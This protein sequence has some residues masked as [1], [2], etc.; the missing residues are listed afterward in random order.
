M[1]KDKKTFFKL[2]CILLA[3]MLVNL[4]LNLAID[5]YGIFKKDLSKRENVPNER[6]VKME[7]LLANTQKYD[8]LLL[9]SSRVAAI[10]A[11]SL[12]GGKFYNL[13]IPISTPR[14]NF[15]YLRIL[16]K[17]GMKIKKVVYGIE[18]ETFRYDTTKHCPLSV[19]GPKY[20]YYPETI[21]EK[22]FFYTQYLFLFPYLNVNKEK[23]VHKDYLTDSGSSAQ[24]YK[25]GI[26]PI[27]KEKFVK[28]RPSQLVY[29]DNNIKI[30]KEIIA[31]CK[32][33]DIELTLFIVPEYKKHYLSQNV[34][35]YNYYKKE[36]AKI[37]DYY[38]FS[39]LNEITK[40][41]KNFFDDK[42]F[43]FKTGTL[44]VDR[45]YNQSKDTNPRIKNFGDY[46]T[47]DNID[48]HIKVLK[49][50]LKNVENSEL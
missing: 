2:G 27:E 24:D 3:I 42:H 1:K 30:L 46:V 44:I 37:Q 7:Y 41:E 9:G 12:E 29:H 49:E 13:A 31:F 40:N 48:E 35:K 39:G 10:N 20:F 21:D 19:F 38:D 8:S 25:G 28:I 45:L 22:L 26:E 32:E 6:F 18:N 17:H 50:Q 33:N 34:D 4:V 47:A 5:N 23:W 14:E 36:L 16:K 43:N 15:R 11:K